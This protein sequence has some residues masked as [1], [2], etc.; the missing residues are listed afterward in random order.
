MSKGLFLKYTICLIIIGWTLSLG[1]R[2]CSAQNRAP[3]FDPVAQCFV[4]EPD[5]DDLNL[6]GGGLEG[7]TFTTC[8]VSEGESLEVY[9]RATDPDGDSVGIAVLNPPPTSLFADLGEGEAS[10]LLVPDYTGPSSSTQ[11]PFVLFFVASDGEL[12]AQLRVSINVIN[13]NR[14]PE[15]IMPES[16]QVA[17]GN[18]LVF[19]VRAED[20]DFEEVTIQAHNLPSQA[21]FEQESGLFSWQP[22]LADTGCWSITFQA[23]DPCGGNSYGESQVKVLTPSTFSLSLGVERTLLGGMVN[24]PINL[25]NSV[26]IA[27]MELLIEYDPTIFHFLDV[28]NLGTR[29]ENWEYLIHHEKTWGSD[30]QIK[31]LGIADFPNQVSQLPLM[32]DSGTILFLKFQ[33]SGD[34]HLDGLLAPLEFF[35]FDFTDNTFSTPRG[36]FITQ[37]MINVNQG[38]VLLSSGEVLIGDV[39]GNGLAFEVGD[40]V[41]LARSLT[42]LTVLTE[43][44]LINSDVNQDG[45][46]ATLSDLV[47]LLNKIIEQ[48]TVPRIDGDQPD[49]V[50]EVK[51][52]EQPLQNL[53]RLDSNT[54]VGGIL[55]IFKGEKA[56]VENIQLSPE[57]E[58]LD[59][60][61]Y[62]EGDEFRVMVISQEAMPL[63]TGESYLFSF[64]GEG[65]DTVEISA[66]NQEGEL[67]AVKQEQEGSSLPIK[68][69]LHQNF[70][71]P[72]NPST[73]IRY[74]VGGDCPV[75]VSLKIYNVAG[76]LVRTLLDDRKSPGEYQVIWDGNNESGQ[77]VSSGMYFY[78]LQVS[79]YTETKKMVLLR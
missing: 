29:T 71:N 55:V 6:H 76:Q 1:A 43:Q 37:Q 20:P 39:N 74:Y 63:P 13:V 68:H 34:P 35:S 19:Q 9:V 7:G 75:K 15:L 45:R 14:E 66:A 42:G 23:I 3:V 16:L 56:K 11:S 77:E 48:G 2:V 21:V 8:Y 26:S 59:L 58:G 18:Q 27:G 60:H 38:G 78:K 12:S 41:K 32:P 53:L 57:A 33:V 73:S 22:Q 24:V 51:I 47:Y 30:E 17:A 4:S 65:Y 62:Q 50:V 10:L 72:F 25:I 69:S 44:Q 64:V 54:P 67:M 5:T 28:S 79:D 46:F 36:Q 70:P 52:T 31:I 40:A 61:I 49:Q